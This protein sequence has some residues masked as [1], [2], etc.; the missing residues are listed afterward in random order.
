MNTALAVKGQHKGYI[1]APQL[2]W[3]EKCQPDPVPSLTEAAVS[4]ISATQ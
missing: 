4:L 3:G 2:T 1:C